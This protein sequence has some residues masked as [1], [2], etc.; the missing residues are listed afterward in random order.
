MSAK[1]AFISEQGRRN[2]MEDSYY[3]YQNHNNP[4]IFGGV[5][6]GHCGDFAAK[7]ATTNLHK[8]FCDF[9]ESGLTPQEAFIQSYQKISAELAHQCSGACAGNF[10]VQNGKIYFAN[11]G[12]VRIVVIG[13]DHFQQLTADHRVDNETERKRIMANGGIIVGSYCYNGDRGLM[14]TRTLGDEYFKPIGIVATPD[15]GVY[16]ISDQDIFLVAACD[17]LF[18]EMSNEE[19]A[20]FSRQFRKPESL[21]EAL[22]NEVLV[23]R[24][25]HDNL[26]II[27]L[28]LTD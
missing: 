23:K 11:V 16:E 25:G 6:D 20:E 5:Y 26:T 21:A 12:D 10:L 19:V 24:N 13:K 7:Y 28:F 14:P 18:D 4:L 1:Y 9:V 17:G 8:T 27:V 22:K 2:H 3:F 15:V